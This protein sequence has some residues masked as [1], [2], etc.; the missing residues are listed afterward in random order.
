VSSSAYY[1]QG[2]CSSGT[3]DFWKSLSLYS[4]YNVR[5]IDGGTAVL[6]MV[7]SSFIVHNNVRMKK[8]A[9]IQ[10]PL[11]TVFGHSSYIN[12]HIMKAVMDKIFS[13][14][15]SWSADKLQPLFKCTVLITYGKIK[16]QQNGMVDCLKLYFA[17]CMGWFG[18]NLWNP[19]TPSKDLSQLALP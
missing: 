15:L 6:W 8:N 10:A 14:H 2:G 13:L 9:T 18:R 17:N 12:C 7:T 3:M 4:V 1:L 19:E 11:T 5:W 16:L